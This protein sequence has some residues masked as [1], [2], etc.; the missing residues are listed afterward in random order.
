MLENLGID[1]SIGL[2]EAYEDYI[3]PSQV[4]QKRKSVEGDIA[5]VKDLGK[6]LIDA[7][8]EADPEAEA[9]RQSV[10][11]GA[12]DMVSRAEEDMGGELL[13]ALRGE[14]GGELE[15]GLRDEYMAGGGLT[16]RESRDL[17]QRSMLG[18][19]NS[20]GMI[21]QN[22]SD[23][24]RMKAKLDGDRKDPSITVE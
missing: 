7:Q 24:N 8:R 17:D 1:P 6:E 15:S 5:M 19:S 18:M 22:V 9:L 21:G 20:R 4:R 23:Y 3:A 13:R 11:G 2:L 14:L 10:L 16:D 12:Q